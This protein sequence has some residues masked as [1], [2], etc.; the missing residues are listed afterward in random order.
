MSVTL[1]GKF[2]WQ[3]RPR[4]FN[5]IPDPYFSASWGADEELFEVETKNWT[6]EGKKELATEEV[7]VI[8]ESWLDVV[9]K[10]RLSFLF[11]FQVK[12]FWHRFLIWWSEIKNWCYTIIY[13]FW[14]QYYNTTTVLFSVYIK[15]LLPL[16]FKDRFL[17]IKDI[18]FHYIEAGRT[19]KAEL[20]LIFSMLEGR[21]TQQT[22]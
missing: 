8:F 4:I 21:K 20:V 16:L 5:Q 22:P 2:Y 13:I 14:I 10:L 7:G 6:S 18:H 12:S 3:N 1:L 19:I 11:F 15:T 17:Y 9:N